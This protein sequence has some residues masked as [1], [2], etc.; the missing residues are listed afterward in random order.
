MLTMFV[1][2]LPLI[3]SLCLLA[4]SHRRERQLGK[5]YEQRCE[6]LY[7]A[8]EHLRNTWP[9]HLKNEARIREYTAAL[10]SLREERN[11]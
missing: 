1:L 4:V 7:T 11:A 8:R 9:E 2:G 3:A 6:E 10:R 5:K